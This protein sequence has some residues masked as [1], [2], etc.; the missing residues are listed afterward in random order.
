MKAIKL[1][2]CLL[3]TIPM[4][5]FCSC[6][7]FGEQEYYCDID[8]VRAVQIVCLNTYIEGEYRFE[9]IILCEISDIAIFIDRLN[10]LK[11]SVNWGD[12]GWLNQG[13]VVIRIDYQNG[14]YDLIH[15]NVQKLNRSG[16]NHNGYFFFDKNEFDS[17]ISD[18][19]T[20]SES[21]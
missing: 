16:V 10:N 2:F 4:L 14:D 21:Q 7:F 8:K 11:H 1:I 19:L 9:Y 5:L 15:P 12:P 17:L 3:S 6:G 20:E 18:Y 13:D